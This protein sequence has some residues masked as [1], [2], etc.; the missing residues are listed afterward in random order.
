MK[1]RAKTNYVIA[2]GLKWRWL[3]LMA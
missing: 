3:I 2:V 1:R